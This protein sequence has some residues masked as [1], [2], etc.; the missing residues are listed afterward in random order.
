T[1]QVSKGST[2][3]GVRAKFK[4]DDE[5]LQA[6]HLECNKKRDHS[7]LK[8]EARSVKRVKTRLN[9]LTCEHCKRRHLDE[10]RRKARACLRCESLKHQVRDCTI[11]F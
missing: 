7:P 6:R 10:Y 8:Q 9:F 4:A 5:T 2:G 3:K 11:L 1:N